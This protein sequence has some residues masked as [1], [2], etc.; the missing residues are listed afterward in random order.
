MDQVLHIPII[1]VTQLSI[2]LRMKLVVYNERDKSKRN[3][4]FNSFEDETLKAKQCKFTLDK[5]SIPL[6]M[7]HI[8]C[9]LLKKNYKILSFNSFEDET[10][11]I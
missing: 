4:A 5:L 9:I 11:R 8:L 2:P 1:S 7:K 3:K 10:Y 6:R